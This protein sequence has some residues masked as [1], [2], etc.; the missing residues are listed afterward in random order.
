MAA[1][2]FNLSA[3]FEETKRILCTNGV[4]AL[5]CY[6][7]DSFEFVHPSKSKEL[8]EEFK[9]VGHNCSVL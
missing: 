3:F 5:S 4:V 2:W 7:L 6:S 8:H 9:K 1:H